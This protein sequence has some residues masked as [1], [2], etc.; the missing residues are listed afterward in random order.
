[1]TT[2]NTSRS[3]RLCSL[4]A[5]RGF[6]IAAMIIVNTPGSWQYI[7]PPLRHA[8]WNGLTPTDLIFPFFLFII[9]VS[10]VFA[11]SKKV[12][13]SNRS[14]L[15][16]HL[17][18]RSLILF[19]IGIGLNLIGSGFSELRLPGVLQRI[20]IVFLSCSLLFLYTDKKTQTYIGISILAFYWLIMKLVPVQEFGAGVLEPGKNLANYIDSIIIPFKMYQGSWDPEGLLSTLP[21]IVSSMSGMITGYILLNNE[22]NKSKLQKIFISGFILLFF[23]LFVNKFFPINKNLWS[24]SYV[25]LTSGLA[26]IFFGCIF[27]LMDV[28]Q[29][30]NWG[31]MGIIWGTNAIT[32]YIIHY[33]LLIPLSQI[34]LGTNSIQEYFMQNS[35]N[36]GI[37]PEFASLSWAL[38]Y[39]MLCFI[40]ILILFKKR[41]FLKV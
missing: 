34:K 32:A 28:K 38:L 12:K 20:A 15:V 33:I 23:G 27:Y 22:N 7:Y 13:T 3:K 35:I 37:T 5:F 16:K 25:L 24:S 11:F 14:S 10:I 1:M 9:G 29:F 39:T 21:A 26:N 17:L 40:P 31:K 8:E 41:I 18:K 4:D 2:N 6:T 19:L 30:I 36:V